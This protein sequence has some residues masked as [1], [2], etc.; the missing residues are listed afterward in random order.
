MTQPPW[1]LTPSPLTPA[2][3]GSLPLVFQGTGTFGEVILATHKETGD[4]VAIKKIR[5]DDKKMGIHVTALREVKYLK[6]LDHPNIVR[7]L[8]VISLKRGIALVFEYMDTDLENVIR[9]RSLV[10]SKGDVK[11]YMLGMLK[12]LKHCHERWVVHRDIKPNNFLISRDGMIKLTDFGLS[13]I[14]GSPDRRYTNQVFARWYRPPELLFGSTCYGPGVDVW[15]LGCVFA[16]LLSRKPW[17]PAE[18]DVEVLSLIFNALGTPK[19]KDWGGLQHMPAYIKFQERDGIP[20]KTQFPGVE[21]EALDL[22]SKMVA[23]DPRRRITAVDALAHPYFKVKPA[24]TEPSMLPKPHV[25]DHH[26][27]NGADDAK[28]KRAEAAADPE[29]MD[30]KKLKALEDV[31]KALF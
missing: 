7:L 8:D 30:P 23:M 6:E 18:S 15:A 2:H 28:R 29:D 12:A 4:V 17:F 24:P 1:P 3:S 21:A 10:L 14:Y 19:G 27:H 9:D 31:T 11:A 25:L 13:R 20:L 26:G 5:V 16:E 22:L